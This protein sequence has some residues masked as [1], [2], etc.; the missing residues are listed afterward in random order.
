MTP[1]VVVITGASRGIGRW[2]AR[3]FAAD[4][5][6]VVL[7]GRDQTQLDAV[8]DEVRD[9]GGQPL[10]LQADLAEPDQI[11]SCF[12][13]VD[14]QCGRVDV[15]VNNAARFDHKK[16][17]WEYSLIEWRDIIDVNVTGTYLFCRAAA[18]RMISGGRGGRII[19]LGAIQQWAPL[20]GWAAYATSKGALAAMTRSLAVELG[21]FG[22]LVNAVVPGG[23]DVRADE[24]ADDPSATLLGR[25]GHPREVA[26]LIRFLASDDCTFVTG[27]MIRCDGGRLLLPRTDPQAPD[28]TPHFQGGSTND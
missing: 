5:D 22:I 26:R 1:R 20:E 15:L 23:V 21:R 14:E 2:T 27:E 8:A 18:Q 4:G 16:N 25:L 12:A 24:L 17:A 7:V 6:R 13:A 19:N 10:P 9:T 3:A 11:D 28:P